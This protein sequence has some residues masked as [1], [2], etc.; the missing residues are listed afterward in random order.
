MKKA[1]V[2]LAEGQFD[3]I[4][5][6]LA[7][8]RRMAILESMGGEECPCQ[9]LI[10]KF[11]ITKGTISHHMKELTRAGLVS[12][13]KDGQFT[14]YETRRD[15]MQAYVEELMRRVHAGLSGENFMHRVHEGFARK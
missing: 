10:K 1:T 5:K 15:V 2:A 11:D 9:L 8:P 3:L 6:A 7:D 4:A 14:S 13:H 12:V